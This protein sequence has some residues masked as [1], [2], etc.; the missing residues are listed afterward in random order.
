MPG[1]NKMVLPALASLLSLAIAGNASAQV[2]AD[3][4]YPTPGKP[5]RIVAPYTPGS[6]LDRTSRHFAEKLSSLWKSPV[7]VENRPGAGGVTGA[8]FVA[9]S[10]PDGY[11]VMMGNSSLTIATDQMDVP[12]F[13]IVRDFSAVSLTAWVP[14]LLVVRQDSALKNLADYVAAGKRP[15][16]AVS[17][18]TPGERTVLHILGEVLKRSAGINMAMIAYK[19]ESPA[20]TDLLGG[21]IDSSFASV[22]LA[23]PL[24][25]GGRVR[26][27]GVTSPVRSKILP[28]VPT[29]P[30]QGYPR[31][32]AVP[33]L[34]MMMPAKTPASIVN[35]LSADINRLVLQ[36]DT[37][38]AMAEI[39]QEAAG[40]L[41]EQFSQFVRSERIKWKELV[42]FAQMPGGSKPK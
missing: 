32:D 12:P 10:A 24:I 34:G 22:S 39:G 2:T 25:E 8:E 18:G 15:N 20:M 41:P 3:A 4:P 13:D 26:A 42:E 31:L 9:K 27:V 14:Y 30:E 36:A 37:I 16:Q 23:R 5:V 6:S 29:F 28:D 1:R 7:V 19:G 38:K 40:M 33:W 35:R 21:H 11:T 17:Y